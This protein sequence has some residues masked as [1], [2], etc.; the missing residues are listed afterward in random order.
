MIRT[1]QKYLEKRFAVLKKNRV[2]APANFESHSGTRVLVH[3]TSMKNRSITTREF[4]PQSTLVRRYLAASAPKT[5]ESSR[6]QIPVV[7]PTEPP[8]WSIALSSILLCAEV[9]SAATIAILVMNSNSGAHSDLLGFVLPSTMVLAEYL[10]IPLLKFP[11]LL[12]SKVMSMRRFQA[13]DRHAEAAFN[14]ESNRWL[15]NDFAVLAVVVFFFLL[16]AGLLHNYGGDSGAGVLVF[17][18]LVALAG[19]GIHLH[20]SPSRVFL[21]VMASIVDGSQRKKRLGL[22]AERAIHEGVDVLGELE[23][24]EFVI[25]CSVPLRMG[26]VDGHRLVQEEGGTVLYCKGLFDDSDRG[27]FYLRQRNAA[28]QIE[29][30]KELVRV[31]LEMLGFSDIK[32][33]KDEESPLPASTTLAPASH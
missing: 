33:L 12:H 21:H 1:F 26:E 27:A 28:A 14:H 24:Q 19:I 3:L 7:F 8:G 4:I 2:P 20:G 25:N 5:P 23:E 15:W 6:L 31:Q 11:A 9:A 22:S 10:G 29:L 32:A 16:K 30:A 17:N 13:N 18:W